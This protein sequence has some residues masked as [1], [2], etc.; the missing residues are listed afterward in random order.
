ML[1][2]AKS[3]TDAIGSWSVGTPGFAPNFGDISFAGPGVGQNFGGDYSGGGDR[4]NDGSPTRSGGLVFGA[5]RTVGQN[6]EK[7]GKGSPFGRIFVENRDET[8]YGDGTKKLL[9]PQTN[10][11]PTNTVTQISSKK[12]F[13]I[14]AVVGIAVGILGLMK[15]G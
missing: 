4:V 8:S 3:I 13:D 12:D 5:T 2:G 1:G 9:Q 6:L 7:N 10:L 11:V 14:L 15:N